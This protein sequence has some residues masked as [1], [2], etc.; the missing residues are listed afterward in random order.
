MA[1]TKADLEAIREATRAAHEAL[2]DL[3]AATAE[4][5]EI[6]P[7]IVSEHLDREVEKAISALAAVTKRTMDTSVEKV[8][9]EFD[10]LSHILMGRTGPDRKQ[11]RTP[12][13]DLIGQPTGRPRAARRIA[14][15]HGPAPA[16]CRCSIPAEDPAGPASRCESAEAGPDWL[17]D[18]CRTT[19][20]TRTKT[21]AA[22]ED[23]D[24]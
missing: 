5:R 18:Y 14:T 7:A 19:C 2:R 15:R 21:P 23:S 10:R 13:P 9:R 3:R 17:C 24:A 22:G 6:A 16:R 11:G 8:I 20:A 4:A 1:D 12:I